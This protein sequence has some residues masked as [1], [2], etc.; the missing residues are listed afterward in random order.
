[1]E[2]PLKTILFSLLVVVLFAVGDS[3]VADDNISWEDFKKQFSKSYKSPADENAHKQAFLANQKFVQDH[4]AK[5]SRGEKSYEVGINHLSDL[6]PEE[7]AKIH[8][9]RPHHSKRHRRQA[10]I[11]CSDYVANPKA[12]IP[13]S[14]DWR[15]K[16]YVT[17]VKNQGQCGSCYSFSATGALEGQL[18]KKTGKLTS[19][20]EQNIVD[21]DTNDGGC[22]G[23]DAMTVFQYV[24]ANGGID[25]ENS[26]PYSDN[27]GTNG[28]AGTCAFNP[29]N[30]GG[31]NVGCVY[32]PPNDETA[33]KNAVATIG[34]I[35]IA[36]YA[37]PP[38]FMNFAGNGTFDDPVCTTP[39]LQSDH[40]VLIVGYGT[41]STG[42][43]YWIIKNSWD[44][45]WGN[46]GYM[47]MVRGKNC[48]VVASESSYPTV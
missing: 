4:S 36:L 2:I 35:S 23:G 6:L 40:A 16:G 8:G 20:S 21:C 38:E 32:L 3:K 1:M 28:V 30:V 39:N 29:A 43:D 48:L 47:N 24:N 33:M 14:V 19:L 26:Y 25:T 44:V 17:P 13:A 5:H 41:D 12:V 37:D 46:N 45:T 18:F 10:T 27:T 9:H 11:E 7:K 34:P 31:T 22:D 42:K 15:T